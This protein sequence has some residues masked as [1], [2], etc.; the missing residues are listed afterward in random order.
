MR[1]D[2]GVIPPGLFPEHRETMSSLG[3][4]TVKLTGPFLSFLFLWNQL[5]KF[6]TPAG[7]NNYD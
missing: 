4:S 7:T 5:L 6:K 3:A 1:W 2:V